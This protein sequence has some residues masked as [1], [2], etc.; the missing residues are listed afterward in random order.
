[1]LEVIRRE[2]VYLWYYFSVQ[3]EQLFPYW[4]LGMLLGSAVSVFLK[5][6]IHETF[7]AMGERHTIRIPLPSSANSSIS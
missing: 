5:D 1:M 2:A 4:V 3:L 6:R 7:R